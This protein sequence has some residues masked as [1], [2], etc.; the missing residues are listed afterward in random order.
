ML[1][2]RHGSAWYCSASRMAA[3][4]SHPEGR[5]KQKSIPKT[6]QQE[7]SPRAR[8]KPSRSSRAFPRFSSP[9]RAFPRHTLAALRLR[10][11]ELGL[12]LPTCSQ[13]RF[14]RGGNT[15]VLPRRSCPP[16][17][18][19]K[20]ACR[21]EGLA[22]LFLSRGHLDSRRPSAERTDD[23][24][25]AACRQLALTPLGEEASP[26]FWKPRGES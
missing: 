19:Q 26:F 5:T 24:L 14:A 10:L 20:P 13:T 17:A 16:S 3:Q 6:D 23:G 12:C 9:S 22:C 25:A 21:P 2:L 8:L 15:L 18:G 1:R 4:F 11:P 7:Q